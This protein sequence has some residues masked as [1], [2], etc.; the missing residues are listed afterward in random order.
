MLTNPYNNRI[1]LYATSKI[2]ILIEIFITLIIPLWNIGVSS[3]ILAS[4]ITPN[5]L[6]RLNIRLSAS[7]V[8][9][10]SLP[11]PKNLGLRLPETQVFRFDK[12]NSHCI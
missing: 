11:R 6:K 2:F 10:Q 9:N 7:K 5:I 3:Q 8:S 4:I 12:W 1:L